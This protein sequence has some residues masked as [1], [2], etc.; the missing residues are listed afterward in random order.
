[1]FAFPV[2]LDDE[3]ELEDVWEFFLLLAGKVDEDAAPAIAVD[4]IAACP[5]WITLLL[6][7]DAVEPRAPTVCS[8]TAAAAAATA[9][10]EDAV[11]S[12]AL[13]TPLETQAF[14][15]RALEIRALDDARVDAVD[16][17]VPASLLSRPS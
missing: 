14:D 5:I 16:A 9:P 12:R 15:R 8:P 3:K 7:R 2:A 17:E 10:P 11:L 13:E 4:M 6:D 1:M